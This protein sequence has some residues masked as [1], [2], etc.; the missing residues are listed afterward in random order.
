MILWPLIKRRDLDSNFEN[1]LRT[2]IPLLIS[3][4]SRSFYSHFWGFPSSVIEL[5]VLFHVFISAFPPL[6]IYWFQ[7]HSNSIV[8]DSVSR[9][10]SNSV[11]IFY[12]HN[13]KSCTSL[14]TINL[15][16]SNE[17][18]SI[19]SKSKYWDLLSD[20]CNFF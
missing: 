13:L 18:R 3:F 8:E 17:N 19:Y 5:F 12:T 11:G 14:Q 7:I 20:T 4:Y 6:D 15:F 10:G 9:N 2:Y 1:L 16:I